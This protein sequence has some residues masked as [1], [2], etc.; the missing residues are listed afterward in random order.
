MIGKYAFRKPT[1]I[2][3]LH[4]KRKQLAKYKGGGNF[5][6]NY[7]YEYFQSGNKALIG[8]AEIH[9][10]NY[11]SS[12]FTPQFTMCVCVLHKREVGTLESIQDISLDNKFSEQ[13]RFPC[14]EGTESRK[15]GQRQKIEDEKKRE[16]NK[17]EGR[18]W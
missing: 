17:G 6:L 4:R 5:Q 16:R 11:F 15:G 2:Y 7:N 12:K 3:N 10:G 9:R 1:A 8:K 14:P 13:R 18:I